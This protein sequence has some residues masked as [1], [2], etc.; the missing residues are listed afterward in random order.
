MMYT[1]Y[2]KPA[3]P[4]CDQAKVLLKLRGLPFEEKILDIGQPK[5]DGKVY[6]SKA[7]LLMAAPGARTV[8][9]I[10]ADNV[11]IGG[12]DE[13]KRSLAHVA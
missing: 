7:A 12:Y 4:F 3:C 6:V 1:V 8:P 13:L 5:I 9:Q 10:L 11:V 2:S